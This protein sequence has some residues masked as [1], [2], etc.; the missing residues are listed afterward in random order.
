MSEVGGGGGGG[1]GGVEHEVQTG[2]P[3]V[4]YCTA[5]PSLALTGFLT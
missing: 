1:L 4:L 5:P 3:P 2:A